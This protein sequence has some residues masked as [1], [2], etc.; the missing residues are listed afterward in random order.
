MERRVSLCWGVQLRRIEKLCGQW[1]N[2]QKLTQSEQFIA[3]A[4]EV[5]PRYSFCLTGLA[6]QPFTIFQ[7]NSHDPSVVQKTAQTRGVGLS[8][9]RVD[10]WIVQT[11]LGAVGGGLE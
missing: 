6:P 7:Q 11:G 2:I 8:F 10:G 9:A 4:G 3:G 1:R 5:S